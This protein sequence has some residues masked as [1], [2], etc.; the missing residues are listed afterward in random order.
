MV[1]LEGFAF[2]LIF[3]L[4]L[5]VISNPSVK[6]GACGRFFNSQILSQYHILF[7]LKHFCL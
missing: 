2:I 4:L 1:Q 7:F 6:V 3:H 5:F